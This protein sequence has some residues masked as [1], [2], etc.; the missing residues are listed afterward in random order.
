VPTVSAVGHEIDVTIADYCADLRAPTPTAAAELIARVKEELVADL[1]QRRA[2]L[3]RAMRGQIERK[4][5]QLDKLRARVADPRRLIGD[6][7]LRLDPGR[8]R[9]GGLGH[10]HIAP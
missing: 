7:K 3:L 2:R 5:G 1:A 4:G 8:P 10:A 9:P 6:R